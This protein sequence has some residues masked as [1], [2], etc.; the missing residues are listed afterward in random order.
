MKTPMTNA[1]TSSSGLLVI[2]K[3]PINTKLQWTPTG[4]PNTLS[5][6]ISDTSPRIWCG[7]DV[8]NRAGAGKAG[9]DRL[10]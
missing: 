5:L 8:A 4:M 2:T 10:G 7:F 6:S 9:R 1:T 3:I